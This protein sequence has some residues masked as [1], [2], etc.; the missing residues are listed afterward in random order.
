[1]SI[2]FLGIGAQK[3]GTTW[4]HH[5]LSLHPQIR[6]PGGKEIHY[7]DKQ[8]PHRYDDYLSLFPDHPPILKFGEI[9][10]AYAILPAEIVTNIHNT[11]PLAK[12]FFITRN[13][14]E[15]AWSSA[16]MAL[17]RSEMR[18]E[19]ASDQ[20]FI[21]H[22]HS[23]GSRL[24]GNYQ[25]TIDLWTRHY[26]AEQFLL[27]SFDEMVGSPELF[28]KKLCAFLDVDTDFFEQHPQRIERNKIFANTAYPLRPTLRPVLETLYP[29]T[30]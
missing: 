10:P 21:D 24:R 30:R 5:H 17:E 11:A 9:T 14:I 7:W 16:L 8:F 13:P 18:V 2:D 22:F 6:F 20:W 12:V 26:P 15:R 28:L 23:Q 4:V 25:R 29:H 3:A 27:L 19:E 1:M